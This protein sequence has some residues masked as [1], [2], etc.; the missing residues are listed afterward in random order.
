MGVTLCMTTHDAR[1][2]P[3]PSLSHPITLTYVLKAPDDNDGGA[4]QR[5]RMSFVPSSLRAERRLKRRGTLKRHQ[6]NVVGVLSAEPAAADDGSILV[7]RHDDSVGQRWARM[8]EAYDCLVGST[9]AAPLRRRRKL[10]RAAIA[11]RLRHVRDFVQTT[12]APV[13]QQF[14]SIAH[15]RL[16]GVVV[17]KLYKRKRE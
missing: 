1:Q 5:V 16:D 3:A 4:C 17:R 12:W 11:E 14:A 2:K 13:D 6:M 10:D 8:I 9:F 15:H 7:V